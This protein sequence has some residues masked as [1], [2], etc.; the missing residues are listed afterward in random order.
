VVAPVDIAALRA[1]R[2]RRIGHHMLAH[3]RPEAY[4][5]AARPAY[6]PGG[7]AK[8]LTIEANDRATADAKARLARR[9]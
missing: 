6:P 1:E 9:D 2:E 5:L 3:R 4:R 8:P 7:A